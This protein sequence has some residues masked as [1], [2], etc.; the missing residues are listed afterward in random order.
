[1]GAGRVRI[2]SGKDPGNEAVITRLRRLEWEEMRVNESPVCEKIGTA[3][4]RRRQGLE[5]PKSF[6]A[7]KG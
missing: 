4:E 5:I 7:M 6:L 3:L 2:G 1:M